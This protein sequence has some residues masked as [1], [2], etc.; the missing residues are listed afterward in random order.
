MIEFESISKSYGKKSVLENINLK[1]ESGSVFG[2]VGINGAGK[3]T[4][5]RLA[6]GVLRPDDGDIYVDGDPVYENESA[7]RKIFFLPD[8]PYYTSNINA[9]GLADMYRAFY[10][11][12]DGV[13]GEY[14]EQFKLSPKS[15]LRTFS[16]GM[17]RQVFVSLALAIRPEYLL[18]DEAF[19][20]LD[21]LARLIFKRGLAALVADKKC[22]VIISSHSLRELE[23]ISDSYGLLDHK[24]ITCSGD[25]EKDLEKIHK[26]QAAFDRPVAR[27]EL[28]FDVLTFSCTGR[29]VQIVAKGNERELAEK[30][31]ALSPLFVEEIPVDFEELFV[32]EVE[33]RGYLQ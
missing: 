14:L 25:L 23:D 10:D 11:F 1:V 16:K 17:K 33:S 31:Q 30:L 2:L 20:G 19:D 21:P 29:V 24:T 27:E 32:S 5:L 3:S 18:L 12:D 9:A 13:Y 4:L 8:D 28:G 22:A 15:P 7:K 6:A 26:F